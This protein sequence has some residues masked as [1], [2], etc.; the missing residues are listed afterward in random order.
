MLK[1]FMTGD[2]HIGLKYA[3]HEKAE[4]I[5]E[6]RIS[7]FDDMVK[8]AN[9]EH[10][11]LFVITGDLFDGLYG[12]SERDVKALLNK[13]SL[14]KGTVAVLP[15]NHDYFDDFDKDKKVWRSFHEV[16]RGMDNIM[17]LSECRPYPLPI[18]EEKVVLYPAPC[19]SE[20]S[21]NNNLDWIKRENILPDATFRIGIAHGAVEGETIDRE[22]QYFLMRRSEL[23]RISVDVWLIG[24]THVPF[25]KNLKT[26]E[27]TSGE[28]IFN[29]GTHVQKD[30]HNNTEGCC[31]VLE[32]GEDKTVRAKKFI[33][34]NLRF[35]REEICVKAGQ[36]RQTLE[37]ELSKF[38]K[39]SV[40]EIFVSGA[41]SEEEYENSKAILDDFRGKFV[42]VKFD[43]AKLTKLIT[44]EKIESEFPEI[45]FSAKFLE[46]LL[47]EPKEA[48]L[49]YD[50]IKSLKGAKK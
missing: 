14:F 34:G 13:L 40:I 28:R 35:Y 50:L 26:N 22:G 48:Q 49:A 38:D 21:E 4:R 32:I 31:F 33:S 36:M 41:V 18:G 29:A 6:A 24:H 16:M 23:L 44:R 25:P 27:W 42:E 2:N 43:D 47:D 12:I 45:S 8:A 30:V 5:V 17:L 20:H 19:T 10:C 9:D 11:S 1:I 46:Q 7:A 3:G 15:G 37:R 39:N